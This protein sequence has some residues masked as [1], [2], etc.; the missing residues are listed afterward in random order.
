[1]EIL[2]IAFAVADPL[3]E[4][5]V[6]ALAALAWADEQRAATWRE[7]RAAAL[8]D[9]NSVALLAAWRES[10]LVAAVVAHLVAGKA[11]V[12][13]L[14]QFVS[15]SEA[16]TAISGPL[17]QQLTAELRRR[18][19][20]IVQTLLAEDETAAAGRLQAGGFWHAA[21]LLYF[22]AEASVL[23]AQQPDLPFSIESFRARDESRLLALLERTYRGTLDCPRIDELRTT[24][25]VVAGHRASGEFHPEFW[26]FAREGPHDI[27]C[28]LVNLHPDVN[29]AE[30][31][32]LGFVPEVRGRGYGRAFTQQAMWLAR[33]AKCDRLVLGVDAANEPA[34]NAYQAAGLT[35][36]ER[37]A[38]WVCSPSGGEGCG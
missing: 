38:L 25:D 27:G 13:W 17:L 16:N 12:A 2:P 32:Y 5:E 18:G 19:V 4:K 6:L 30:L 31:V 15:A 26:L 22:A 3:A 28:L 20:Q 14:P 11:A 9:P 21:N 34:V 10:Q 1:M 24:A 8:A 35:V 36:W 33:Q 7:I 37:R 23:P 29:H